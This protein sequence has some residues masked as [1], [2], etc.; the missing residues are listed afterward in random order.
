MSHFGFNPHPAVV[1]VDN[2]F[3]DRQAEAG[4]LRGLDI[5]AA[6]ELVK[7]VRLVVER[8]ARPESFTSKMI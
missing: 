4:T 7:D 3:D 5:A 8:D 1:A 6:K 2:G